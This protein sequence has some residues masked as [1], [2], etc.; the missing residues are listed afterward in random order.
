MTRIGTSYFNSLWDAKQYYHRQG[1]EWPLT[2]VREMVRLGEIH[3]G[4]PPIS[5]NERV[6]LD[7]DNRW[8]IETK[9]SRL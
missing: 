4:V 2:E 1:Y 7:R 9:G 3:I 8:V 6:F 5:E